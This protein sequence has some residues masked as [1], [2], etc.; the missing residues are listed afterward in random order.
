MGRE[1]NK[2]INLGFAYIAL[3]AVFFFKVNI[4]YHLFTI[5]FKENF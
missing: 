3:A 4:S 5:I 1:K 2:A